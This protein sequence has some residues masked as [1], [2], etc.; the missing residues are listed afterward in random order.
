MKTLIQ[1]LFKTLNDLFYKIYTE[2]IETTLWSYL[3]AN[4][5]KSKSQKS[6]SSQLKI[7]ESLFPYHYLYL[8]SSKFVQPPF[9]RN[10]F[11]RFYFYF[12][13]S[14]D[15]IDTEKAK[16]NKTIPCLISFNIRYKKKLFSTINFEK[17]KK[18]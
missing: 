12:I 15:E 18:K 1:N 10:I 7:S 5:K 8:L 11:H 9:K 6:T 17:K 2:K 16:I 13:E 14:G 3:S 4:N